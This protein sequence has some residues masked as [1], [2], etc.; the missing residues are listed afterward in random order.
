M[1]FPVCTSC[2]KS[3]RSPNRARYCA[4]CAHALAQFE[5]RFCTHTET[6]QRYL[7]EALNALTAAACR[8]S[9]REGSEI[10]RVI[11]D[12]ERAAERLTNLEN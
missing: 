3:T 9:W 7:D 5:D 4:G 2:G 10:A 1:P 11:G 6:A 12:I 8:A